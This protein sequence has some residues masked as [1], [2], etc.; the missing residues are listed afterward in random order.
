MIIPVYGIH[1]HPQLE[2]PDKAR[3]SIPGV[4]PCIEAFDKTDKN[5]RL[6]VQ[7]ERIRV[8]YRM[9][10]EKIRRIDPLPLLMWNDELLND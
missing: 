1:A 3:P 5:H 10:C 2:V 9:I 8:L 7:H 4:V 6:D